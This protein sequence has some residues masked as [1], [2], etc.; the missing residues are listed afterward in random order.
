MV[1]IHKDPSVQ[2]LIQKMR[3]GVPQRIMPDGNT[4]FRIS[5]DSIE[6]LASLGPMMIDTMQHMAQHDPSHLGRLGA[7]QVMNNIAC[8]YPTERKR[9]RKIVE[10]LAQIAPD[11]AMRQSASFA[12]QILR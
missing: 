2:Q 9:V 4:R 7:L 3:R 1:M 6:A 5:Q 10:E 12:M 8:T 11:P